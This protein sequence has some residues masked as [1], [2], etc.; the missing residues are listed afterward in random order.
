MADTDTAIR[1]PLSFASKF[2]YS[3]GSAAYG[4]KGVALGAVMLYYNQVLG[5]PVIWVS[6][7]IGVALIVDAI[8]S[9]VVGQISDM[10]R[11]SW[12][13]RHPFM[14]FSAA[15]VAIA[16]WALFSPPHG[17]SNANL[18]AYM[19]ACII[20]ARVALAMFEIPNSSLMPE[21]VTNYHERTTILSYRYFMSI[22]APVVASF[23]GLNLLLKP[24]V[25]AQG[26]H[27]P[28]QLNPAGYPMAGLSLAICIF[29]AIMISSLGTHRE[30][31][32]MRPPVKH[33]SLGSLFGVIATTLFNRNFLALTTAGI[34]YAVGVG[35]VGG[36]GAYINT[37][38][39]ELSAHEIS[40]ITLSSI[41]APLIAIPLGP[42][43]AKKFGK[44]R[45]VL[46]NFFASVFIGIIPLSLRLVGILPPNGDPVIIPI[47]IMDTIL[48]GTLS[49]MGFIIVSSMFADIVE[50]VQ[51]E[52][53][54]RSEG[55][56]FSADTMLKQIVSGVG[57]MGTGYILAFIRFPAKA[58]P[59]E[60]PQEVLTTLVLIYLP[61]M[62][63]ASIVA[64]SLIS[65]YSISRQQHES[66]LAKIGAAPGASHAATAIEPDQERGLA[67][68]SA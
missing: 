36:L 64:I 33:A 40:L 56:L 26:H 63:L 57:A 24:F 11:S 16:V 44:K 55:L 14:Y 29:A 67:S 17:W 31:K 7:G 23:I 25:N 10:W 30:I 62:T 49:I 18:F 27:M 46:W 48:S 50:Q 5:L 43:I 59:G 28:G 1:P 9:P 20:I 2:S 21:M 4:L 58:I 19:L 6:Q 53:G 35:V 61:I 66:N 37:Y 12:G 38:F 54:K 60:V 22:F 32:Y 65:F 68:E 47:L 34:V 39:W 51:V 15:P 41:C 42:F 52:T 8:A 45:A 13:R 3:V